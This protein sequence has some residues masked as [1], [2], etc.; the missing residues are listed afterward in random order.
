MN[1]INFLLCCFIAFLFGHSLFAELIIVKKED[2]KLVALT[3]SD[4]QKY[5]SKITEILQKYQW[6]MCIAS[7]LT[8]EEK[9]QLLRSDKPCA[10]EQFIQRKLQESI[11]PYDCDLQVVFVPTTLYELFMIQQFFSQED[12]MLRKSVNQWLRVD[13]WSARNPDSYKKSIDLGSIVDNPDLDLQTM[14]TKIFGLNVQAVYKKIFETYKCENDRFIKSEQS[15]LL[16]FNNELALKLFLACPELQDS[17]DGIHGSKKIELRSTSIVKQL[18][19]ENITLKEKN[20][21]NYFPR[22][23]NYNDKIYSMVTGFSSKINFSI[24][25]RYK[26]HEYEA[27]ELN[28]AL[29]VRGTS[30]E[31]FDVTVEGIQSS[32]TLLGNSF[33]NYQWEDVYDENGKYKSYERR[34]FVEAYKKQQVAPY[35]VS[36]GAS[37]FGGFIRDN[38]A[39]A[40]CYLTR[41][42]SSIRGYSLF[43]DKQKYIEDRESNLFF[44]PPLSTIASLFGD[45]EYFHPRSV[46]VMA[47]KTDKKQSIEGMAELKLR[48]PAGIFLIERDP[49]HQAELFSNFIA[50]NGRIIQDD[51]E[52][53]EEDEKIIQNILVAQMKAAQ[54]YKAIRTTAEKN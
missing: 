31:K 39:C 20:K 36:F 19:Q 40:Y 28:K 24:I 21:I 44:I 32:H 14:Y 9:V 51:S 33:R 25:E 48:D 53:L 5:G 18:I 17:I 34:S 15:A 47:K 30:C 11:D 4:I 22:C 8:E 2:N 6:P 1:K 12:S 16:E 10:E 38:G 49:L 46:A 43:V 13:Q 50:K 41:D 29:L 35:S 37:L 52:I 42:H 54:D 27:R 45:G 7:D 3:D 23:V 26:N